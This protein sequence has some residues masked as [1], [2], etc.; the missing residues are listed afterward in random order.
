MRR[1]MRALTNR[2]KLRVIDLFAVVDLGETLD[3]IIA[4]A[5]EQLDAGP[6][7]EQLVALEGLQSNTREVRRFLKTVYA[8]LW[9]SRLGVDV[10][11][12]WGEAA[13]TRDDINAIKVEGGVRVLTIK[14]KRVIAAYRR[15][16]L[17]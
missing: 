15:L 10:F 12:T 1:W 2:Q 5:H 13:S 6:L 11:Q 3:S 4:S 7:V 14:P 16:Y 8:H 9:W 17:Y